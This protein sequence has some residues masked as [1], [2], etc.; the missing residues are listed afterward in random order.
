MIILIEG[1]TGTGK[2]W[3]M[4][5]LIKKEW[6]NGEKVFPNFQLWY[7]VARSEINRWHNIDEVTHLK[8]G[9]IAIDESQKILDARRWQSLPHTFTDLIAM[10]RHHHLDIYTT[11][12]DFNDIDVRVR[13][14]VHELYRCE[15]VLRIPRNQRVKPIIHI[16]SVTKS[17][18]KFTK[19]DTR[20]VRWR[21]VGNKKFYFISKYWTKTYYNTYGEVGQEKY[22]CKIKYQRKKGQKK[23]EWTAKLY[24][25]ELVDRGKA[26]I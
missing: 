8:N 12:Q 17:L 14:N 3:L 6:D 24:S 21:K 15:T 19:T 23:G 7:D 2:T 22:I 4:T 10:H 20:A 16:M 18:R 26:R 11:T 9:I 13:K 5:R 25:R 1:Q